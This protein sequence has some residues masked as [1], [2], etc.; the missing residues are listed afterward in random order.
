MRISELASEQIVAMCINGK[1][2]SVRAKGESF[3]QKIR[4]SCGKCVDCYSQRA[5]NWAYR[6]NSQYLYSDNAYF[7]TLTLDDENLTEAPCKKTIQ[8]FHKNLRQYFKRKYPEYEAKMK[9]FLVSEYGYQ[10]ERL[11]YHAIYYNFPYDYTVPYIQISNEIAKIW[12]KG[13]VYVKPF[14]FNQINYCIKYL[15]KDKE[16]GNIRMSSTQLGQIDEALIKYMNSTPYFENIKVNT[17]Y[18][19]AIPMPRY[20]R[21]KYMSDEQKV[22]FGDYFQQKN[23]KEFEKFGFKTK[24]YNFE[25]RQK[26]WL[27]T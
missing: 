10:T 4:T 16:L 22:L 8:Q 12:K 14:E 11:H 21:K 24:L 6:C 3:S 15:H 26:K 18:G 1:I 17:A 9:F 25:L 7:V 19:K 5:S 2:I 23:E 20:F 27:Q 13:I